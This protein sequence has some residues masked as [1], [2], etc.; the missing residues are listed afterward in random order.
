MTTAANI[1][2]P[3]HER[4]ERSLS[5][6]VRP[7]GV[8]VITYDVP[9]S[10][11]NTLRADFAQEFSAMVQEVARNDAIRAA[12]LVSGKPDT[13]IAGADLEMLGR[14]SSAAEA[15]GVVEAGHQ[16]LRRLAASSKPVVAAVHG[17][18]LGGG[19]EVALACHGRVLTESSKTVLSLPEVQLGLL[20]GLGGLLRL[21]ERA[22][23]QVAL[24]Y[25][26]TGKKMVPRKARA[27]GIADDVVP[28]AIL[29]QTAAKLALSLAEGGAPSKA[30]KAPAQQA[31]SAAMLEK[32]AVGRALVFKKA[33]QAV[34]K[35]TGGHYPAPERILEVLEVWAKKGFE[36]A[37]TAELEAFG[38]LAVSD[39]ARRLIEIFFATTALKKDLG[40]RG[41][42]VEPR[43]IRQVEILGAGLMGA[44]IASVSLESGIG[45]RLKDQSVEALGKGLE[46]VASFF[47]ERVKR[48]RLTR[49]EREQCLAKLTTTT[50]CSGLRRADIV[51]EA[52]FE[53]LEI[54]HRVLREVEEH[55]REGLIF[56][57]NTSSI[58]I[59]Q[60]A[61][62]AK[63][64]ENVVGMHYFSP[65]PKMPLLEVIATG[66]TSPEVVATAVALGKKQGKTVI[67]VRDGAGFYTSRIL[68]P[69]LNEAAW[70]LTEGA[71][72]ER[73]DAALT[74]WGWPVGPLALLD[75]V[76][77]DVA[78]HV[79]PTMVAAFGSRLE[80]PPAMAKL[81]ADDRRG[82]K[83][84]RG[85]YLYGAARRK[86]RPL[87]GKGSA[88][89]KLADPSVYP[90]LGL[91]VPNPRKPAVAVHEMQLRC[92]LALVNEA[93]RC[94]GEEVVQSPRDADIGAIFGLGFP[95]FRGGP[96]R[97]VDALG[98]SEVLRRIEGYAE[99]FGERWAPASALVELAKKG[100]RFYA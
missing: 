76:G 19:F 55:G 21:A 24:D 32:N 30:K 14:V 13:W 10:A 9:G 95:P 61:S 66:K 81:A 43:E 47:D 11:V 20:P 74:A 16:A 46:S 87:L 58:P 77:I 57:S 33:R 54:K 69:Y 8:A 48:R 18:A 65:V 99:R 40:V 27:L 93:I 50:D 39:V 60:I 34:L 44:G 42:S 73:I 86:R 45:V 59:T 6:E 67:V 2:E 83:N 94:L 79:A 29:Q 12:I 96:F 62:A 90:L 17:A 5:L 71:A 52:V 37:S 72:I 23:L 100:G 68:G 35:R 53:D 1:T 84:E 97:Y 4:P 51:I 56:A 26:L 92:S 98:P 75:E 49:T 78:A 3:D 31:L 63:R 15:R 36:A 64:P 80:P 28:E 25:G 7:D 22:G 88:K 82:K 38:E 70:L 91:P 89:G 85:L 41:A